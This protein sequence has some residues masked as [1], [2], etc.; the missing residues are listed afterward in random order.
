MR[1]AVGSLATIGRNNGYINKGRMMAG[2]E[3]HLT[4]TNQGLEVIKVDAENNYI[5]VKGNVPGPKRGLVI[6]KQTVKKRNAKA[7]KELVDYSGK[8]EE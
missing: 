3:G 4:T 1:R 5:L 2:H 6:V 8:G 7:A